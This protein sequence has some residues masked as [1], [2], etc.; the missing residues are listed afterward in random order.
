MAWTDP[1]NVI[2]VDMPIAPRE[3]TD[4]YPSHLANYG[5]GGWHSIASRSATDA[6]EC[7][8]PRP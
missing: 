1:S 5:R 6:T 4:S 8:P 2:P 3:P 7:Q